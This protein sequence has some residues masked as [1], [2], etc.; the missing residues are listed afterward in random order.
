M[1]GW[2]LASHKVKFW[3]NY[4]GCHAAARNPPSCLKSLRPWT[5][6]FS[7][8]W[9]F[10]RRVAHKQN[11]LHKTVRSCSI[12]RVLGLNMDIRWKHLNFKTD[13]RTHASHAN[14]NICKSIMYTYPYLHAVKH[15]CVYLFRLQN[16]WAKH[17]EDDF[18]CTMYAL[19]RTN[20]CTFS[21]N[22]PL[23][24]MIFTKLVPFAMQWCT[25]MKPLRRLWEK[26]LFLNRCG[27]TQRWRGIAEVSLSHKLQGLFHYC[28]IDRCTVTTRPSAAWNDIDIHRLGHIGCTHDG[29]WWLMAQCTTRCPISL[30]LHIFQA[31]A[32]STDSTAGFQSAELSKNKMNKGARI[33]SAV[34]FILL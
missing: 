10:T 22:M 21:R 16:C 24:S 2:I 25:L 6:R 14:T 18:N 20:F 28:H 33:F 19:S 7:L 27:E 11:L 8:Q 5:W 3:K 15:S 9:L 23:S 30:A 26:T 4:V 34:F 12:A 29:P 17:A 31:E 13:T 1:S 32:S